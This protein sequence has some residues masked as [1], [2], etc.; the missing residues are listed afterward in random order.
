MHKLVRSL[1]T[2]LVVALPMLLAAV[3]AA[4]AD[5]N[6]PDDMLPGPVSDVVAVVGT[7]TISP[8]LPCTGCTIDFGFSALVVGDDEP[9][10][11]TGCTF[12]GTSSG[13]EDEFGG[14]G[15][16]TLGGCAAT[17]TVTYTRTG[18]LV[19]VNGNDVT[20]NGEKHVIRT[21]ALVFVPTSVQ[22]TTSFAVVGTVVLED[23]KC[24]TTTPPTC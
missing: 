22:P 20:I 19:Q 4:H 18:V 24:E 5:P 17:G 8:G 3:P 1:F 14:A 21:S 2:P 6:D 12:H 7:G 13:T 23:A 9:G 10:L 16:G 15:S 11:F